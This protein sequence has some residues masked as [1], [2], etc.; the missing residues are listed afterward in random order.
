MSSEERLALV[1]LGAPGRA[2]VAPTDSVELRMWEALADGPADLDT[3][4][5]R[6]ALP[7]HEGMAAVSS[8]EIGGY[9]QCEMTGEIR[10][11]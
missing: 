10:R 2:R 1:G 9:I 4:C 6:A 5:A 11:R 8:L 3:L 7:A